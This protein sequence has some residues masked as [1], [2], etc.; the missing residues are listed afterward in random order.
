[1][2]LSECLFINQVML[3]NGIMMPTI[4]FGTAGLGEG[5][6]AAVAEALKAGYRHL[7]S[8]QVWTAPRCESW[9]GIQ[10]IWE[11][12]LSLSPLSLK[13]QSLNEVVTGM[14]RWQVWNGGRYGMVAGMEYLLI[15]ALF[16]LPSDSDSYLTIY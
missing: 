2:P 10:N 16:Q 4:G 9:T 3:N 14:E 8:A 1:M 11:L 6:E 13:P 15:W 7:D 12:G 5:T